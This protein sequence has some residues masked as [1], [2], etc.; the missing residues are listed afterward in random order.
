MNTK[1]LLRR[2][3][4]VLTAFFLAAA[5]VIPMVVPVYAQNSR[6]ISEVTLTAGEAAAGQ[7]EKDGWSVM[8]TGLNRDVSADRQVYLAYKTNTGDPI[9]NVMIADDAGESLIDHNGISYDRASETDVDEGVGGGAGCLYY[10]RDKKAGTP[11]VGFDILRSKEEPLYPITNDGAEIVRTAEGVPADLEMA[12]EKNVI[13]LAQIRDG[14]VRPYISEIGVVI[15]TDKWNAVYTACERGYHYYVDGDIDG[16]DD[17]Y[18]LLVYKRTADVQQAVTNIAA[19]SADAVKEMEERQILDDAAFSNNLTGDTIGISGVE[20]VRVSKNP[21]EAQ[22]PYY[23]YQ[24]KNTSAGNPVSMLYKETLEEA[25]N[26]IFGTWAQ[27]YFFSEDAATNAAAFSANENLYSELCD[28]LTVCTKLPVQYLDGIPSV[29]TAEPAAEKTTSEGIEETTVE[30]TEIRDGMSDATQ[31]ATEENVA[32]TAMETTQTT[33][34][35][36]AE[37]EPKYINILMLTPRDGLPQSVSQITGLHDHLSETPIA[38]SDARSERN[39]ELYASVFGKG[40]PALVI[41]GIVIAAGVVS[42]IVI[43]KKKLKGAK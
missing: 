10:T 8:M 39:N 32:E 11:L 25:Q 2:I 40:G 4:S 17:T 7:L 16:S 27:E 1:H 18:T 22:K 13:Y 41:G 36:L 15:D 42:A 21:I 30:S 28:D 20:Y 35:A 29:K 14:I 9:T 43:R 38:E 6:F 23:L 34:E 5:T 26:F 37:A 12:A 19:V 33:A 3:L 24:T 31:D